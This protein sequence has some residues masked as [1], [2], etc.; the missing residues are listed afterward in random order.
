[1]NDR[2]FLINGITFQLN[3]IDAM[4]Q[5]HV[6]R[7]VGP[8]LSELLPAL[9]K[10]SEKKGE[11][12]PDESL[13]NISAFLTPIMNGLSLLNDNDAE[14]VLKSLLSAVE[15]KQPTGNF[16]KVSNGTMIMFSDL[17]L[18]TLLQLAGRAFVYNLSGFFSAL[19]RS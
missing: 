12:K 13:E 19:Q 16:A 4:K 2:E 17:E 8:I 11:E 15:M 1:M 5:F 3:R 10:I 18:P 14:F 6:V 7:R 9:K